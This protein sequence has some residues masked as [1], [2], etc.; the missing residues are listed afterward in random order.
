LVVF[1]PSVTEGSGR[2]SAT[3]SHAAPTEWARASEAEGRH[4][5]TRR[6]SSSGREWR[7]AIDHIHEA[8]VTNRRAEVWD[9]QHLA[10]HIISSRAMGNT[11]DTPEVRRAATDAYY[12]QCVDPRG[13]A[14]LHCS[15]THTSHTHTPFPHTRPPRRARAGCRA[16]WPRGRSTQAL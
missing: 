1:A 10:G 16:S 14:Q 7:V 12:A 13:A 6:S 3:A 2:V 4:W 8:N 9:T 5:R 15:P 11:M